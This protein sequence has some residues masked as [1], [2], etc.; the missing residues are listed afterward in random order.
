MSSISDLASS[1]INSLDGV[2]SVLVSGDNNGVI[3]TWSLDQ[4]TTTL[5]N[6]HKIGREMMWM[7]EMKYLLMDWMIKIKKNKTRMKKQDQYSCN[8]LNRPF[9]D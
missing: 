3:N 9:L 8:I 4:E 6:R 2:T 1:N 7:V 5:V